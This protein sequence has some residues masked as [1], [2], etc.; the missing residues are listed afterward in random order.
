[1]CLII[2]FLPLEAQKIKT[3]PLCATN[4]DACLIWL[5]SKKSSLSRYLEDECTKQGEDLYL[6]VLL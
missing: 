3:I 2:F 1:M 6:V 5:R 4:Q